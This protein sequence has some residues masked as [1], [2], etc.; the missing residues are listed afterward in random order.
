MESMFLEYFLERCINHLQFYV[1]KRGKPTTQRS[2]EKNIAAHALVTFES[3][4]P[5]MDFPSYFSE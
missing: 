3:K 1:M 5:V 2:I 4:G